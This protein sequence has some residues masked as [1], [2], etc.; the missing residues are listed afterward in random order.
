LSDASA[1]GVTP[2]V[3]NSQYQDEI[4]RLGPFAYYPVNEVAG[5]T[6]F[7]H[8]GN[9]FNATYGVGP[10][11]L[12]TPSLIPTSSD[13]SSTVVNVD[14]IT[15]AAVAP[16]TMQACTFLGWFS[17]LTPAA[18]AAI[19]T[20]GAPGTFWGALYLS[21]GVLTAQW[22]SVGPIAHT[23]AGVGDLRDGGRHFVAGTYDGATLKVYQDGVQAGAGTAA[24][25]ALINGSYFIG[26]ASQCPGVVASQI[27]GTRD[28]LAIFDYAL[29]AAEIANLYTLA[30]Q[31]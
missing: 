16:V 8:S 22:D 13:K 17:T 15:S 20:V 6:A 9:G 12:G 31:T 10:H 14:C 19:L 1:G 21:A 23:T 26:V 24:A 18:T 3:P 5:V 29:S 2:S 25:F 28:E 4:I 30:T 27:G 11:T 7:D